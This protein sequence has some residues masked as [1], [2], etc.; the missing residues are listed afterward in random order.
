MPGVAQ[1]WPRTVCRFSAIVAVGGGTTEEPADGNVKMA[2]EWGKPQYSHLTIGPDPRANWGGLV[3]TMS[4]AAGREGH[5]VRL[6]R[7]ARSMNGREGS[8]NEFR[9]YPGRLGML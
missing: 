4:A 2:F 3:G 8:K 7:E 6:E 1:A 5:H 9:A